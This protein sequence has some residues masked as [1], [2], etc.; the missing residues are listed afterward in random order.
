VVRRWETAG[1]SNGT[2]MAISDPDKNGH[3]LDRLYLKKPQL[4]IVWLMLA[5]KGH[6]AVKKHSR[7]LLTI[8]AVL[9]IMLLLLWL[10]HEPLSELLSL[11]GDRQS[12]GA[13]LRG[14]G[15]WGPVLI[16]L[17]QFLQVVIAIIPGHAL[18]VVSGY[19][20][21]F[22]FGF[23]LNL[24]TV[25][26]ASQLAFYLAR[27]AGQPVVRHLVSEEVLQRWTKVTEKNGLAFFMISFMIPVFPADILNF[28]AGLS[29]MPSNQFLAASFFG[30][31]PAL[32]L[33]TLVGAKGSEIS[34]EGWL[35]V[36]VVLTAMFAA[37][38]LDFT[39]F[40]EKY[41]SSEPCQV[42]TELMEICC[43]EVENGG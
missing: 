29:P 42:C 40:K 35:I 7:R 33:M 34:L 9:V 13:F 38:H 1:E 15:I 6:N 24:V 36:A 12:L 11:I 28:V 43:E 25:V 37:W 27:R 20:Y 23:V 19:V 26:A 41:L 17:L 32:I 21:G 3:R 16:A 39:R 2:E 8:S 31:L 5:G 22:I 4:K 30:R 14:S 10:F 18:M